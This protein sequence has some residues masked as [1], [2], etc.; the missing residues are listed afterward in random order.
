MDFNVDINLFCYCVF[1]KMLSKILNRNIFYWRWLSIKI[2]KEVENIKFIWFFIERE[3]V[4]IFIKL[5][6]MS[7]LR[8]F[9]FRV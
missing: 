7:I 8:V 1:I 6:Y 2:N 5:Y 4:F 9:V 3:V